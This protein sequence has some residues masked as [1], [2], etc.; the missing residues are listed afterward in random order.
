MW[1]SVRGCGQLSSSASFVARHSFI[2]GAGVPSERRM[3]RYEETIGAMTEETA[4]GCM[5]IQAMILNDACESN[6]D[7]RNKCLQCS[8][9][10]GFRKVGRRSLKAARE[11]RA[12]A[13]ASSIGN[14]SAVCSSPRCL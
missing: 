1:S 10:P 5:D 9:M 11:L 2:K 6:K 14:P 3:T 13:R 7:S 8:G 12:F 4:L